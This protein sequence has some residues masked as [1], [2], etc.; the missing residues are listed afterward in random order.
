ML[1]PWHGSEPRFPGVV[2]SADF[3]AGTVAV[4]FDDGDVDHAV[5]VAS[6]KFEAGAQAK[7]PPKGKRPGLQ[8]LKAKKRQRKL[9]LAQAPRTAGHSGAVEPQDRDWALHKVIGLKILPP[10]PGERHYD[11]VDNRMQVE[12]QWLWAG[13]EQETE[14]FPADRIGRMSLRQILNQYPHV[15]GMFLVALRHFCIDLAKA[16]PKHEIAIANIF[17]GYD[18]IDH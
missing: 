9:R 1:A 10:K 4:H 3:K 11:N 18:P 14:D 2:K 12:Y 13:E 6:I 17:G 7:L 16:H 15:T 8:V 5:K